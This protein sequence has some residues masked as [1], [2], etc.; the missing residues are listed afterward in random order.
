MESVSNSENFATLIWGSPHTWIEANQSIDRLVQ[1]H[2]SSLGKA[3]ALSGEIR[4]KIETVS[5]L[6][7]TL[8]ASTCPWCPEPCCLSAKVWF[9]FKDLIFIHLN[10]FQH[11]VAQPIANLE[12]TCQYIGLRGCTL[13]R[14]FRPWICTCYLCPTQ[15]A[16]LRNKNPEY[17]RSISRLIQDIKNLR[18]VLEDVFIRIVS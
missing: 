4:K 5:P 12:K 17:H 3:F 10:N 2:H 14:I 13:N 1:N 11:P 16:I 6:M 15:M 18:K 8:C 7:D 9:D